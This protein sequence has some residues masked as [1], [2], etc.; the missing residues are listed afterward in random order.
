MPLL[1]RWDPFEEVERLADRWFREPWG[2]G[3]RRGML[4]P[5]VDVYETD[6]QVELRA[7]LPGMKPEDVRIEIT[8]HTITL[9]GE[10]RLEHEDS[11][12][13]YRRIECEYGSFSRSF[14]LPRTV[15]V[16]KIEAEMHDGVLRLI[17]PKVS[18]EKKREI[19]IRTLESQASKEKGKK[20]GKEQPVA[21]ASS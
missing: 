7:E 13:N 17:V 10:R 20:A 9:S 18:A 8:D 16:E 21:E 11:R 12:E 14:T 19:P 1:T 6:E 2:W 4:A 3:M 15:D 5:A